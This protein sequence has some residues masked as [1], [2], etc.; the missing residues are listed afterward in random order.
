M[1]FL[2]S[3]VAGSVAARC[4][5]GAGGPVSSS[6]FGAADSTLDH[7]SAVAVA[8][9]PRSADHGLDKTDDW[10][11]LVD[12]SVQ[13]GQEKCLVILGI[14]LKDLPAQGE[15]LQHTDLHLIALVPRKSWTRQE[16]DEE[17][18]AASQRTGIP[19]VIVDDHGVDIAGGVSFFQERHPETV[20][21]YD[22][23][24]KAACLLKNRLEKNRALAGIAA[25]GRTN[26][27]CDSTDRNGV[28][29]S[30]GSQ[31]EGAVYESGADLAV[32]RK[33]AGGV[34]TIADCGERAGESG[35]LGREVRM[36]A[37]I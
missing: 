8:F 6:G 11:W 9:G 18:E 36:A 26:A 16:V 3:G 2:A 22:A 31:A 13:I 27:L 37:G 34:A 20:E 33:R 7:R 24:H 21:I 15:C 12:H 14:R 19:R 4:A 25:T 10:A 32:G 28:L 35:T 5:A 17:L 23:K 30:P 29:G 1:P